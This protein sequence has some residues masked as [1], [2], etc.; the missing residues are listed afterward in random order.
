MKYILITAIG[1]LLGWILNALADILPSDSGSIRP[2]CSACASPYPIGDYL[3]RYRCP[4]CGKRRSLRVPLVQL[5]ALGIS[6]L[7]YF[8]PPP[9]LTYWTT[10]PLVILLGTIFI[11]DIEHRL[12]LLK[13]IA[14]AAVLFLLYGI[15]LFGWKTTLLGALGGLGITLSFYFLGIGVSKLVGAIRHKQVSEVAFGLGDV[16]AATVFGLLVGWPSIVGVIVIAIASFAAFSLITLIV[17][18]LT[19]KYSAFANALP[20]APF[21]ILGIV[22]IYYL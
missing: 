13:T 10:L 9:L 15:L 21:L 6:F 2:I 18:I 8:Y 11:I 20:F 3:F 1:L 17:L 7:I 12:V 19:K 14:V 4:N 16:T 22:V 5:A